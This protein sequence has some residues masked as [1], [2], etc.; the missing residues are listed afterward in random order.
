MQYELTQR[1]WS[2]LRVPDV[3]IFINLQVSN[4]HQCFTA[5]NEISVSFKVLCIRSSARPLLNEL[6]S[7]SGGRLLSP[8]LGMWLTNLPCNNIANVHE[9]CT[10]YCCIKD[11]ACRYIGLTGM[12]IIISTAI[13]LHSLVHI[14]TYWCRRTTSE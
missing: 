12:F 3:I 4:H 13:T 1:P 10:L 5:E 14:Y 2:F 7:E 6:V 11:I 9:Q 8:R